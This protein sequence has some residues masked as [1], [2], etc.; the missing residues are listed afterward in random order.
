MVTRVNIL[1]RGWWFFL[2][3]VTVCCGR[4]YAEDA[5]GPAYAWTDDFSSYADGSLG[6]PRWSP[7]AIDMTVKDVDYWVDGRLD[8]MSVGGEVPLC[9]PVEV[10][11][12]G[13]QLPRTV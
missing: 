12:T 3:C 7:E 11:A 13:F 1:R 2:F 5:G 9:R 4:G 8:S 6:D 10:E